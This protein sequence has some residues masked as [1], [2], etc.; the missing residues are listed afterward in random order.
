MNSTNCTHEL[1]HCL[2]DINICWTYCVFVFCRIHWLVEGLTPDEIKN[3]SLLATPS[4]DSFKLDLSSLQ[5]LKHWMLINKLATRSGNKLLAFKSYGFTYR[6]SH[7]EICTFWLSIN[8]SIL[9]MVWTVCVFFLWG[10]LR[11]QVY[12]SRFNND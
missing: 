3:E 8:F 6:K 5:V 12:S 10:N 1:H 11:K 9:D 7:K 2:V 4:T